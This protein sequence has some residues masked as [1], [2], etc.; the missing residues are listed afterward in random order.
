[1]ASGFLSADAVT[2]RGSV[3]RRSDRRRQAARI[4]TGA[5]SRPTVV[6]DALEY[7]GLG[8]STFC[9]RPDH[10]LFVSVVPP[11]H[12]LG[13][14]L[15]QVTVPIA[16]SVTRAVDAGLVSLPSSIVEPLIAF[17]SL[18]RRREP[19]A[20]ELSPWRGALVLVGLLHA[21]F[22]GSSTSRHA[23]EQFGLALVSSTSA[24]SRPVAVI[25]WRRRGGGG[26]SRR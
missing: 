9:P 19:V 6:V 7:P 25:D 10:I 4:L 14:L 11:R 17:R 22:A 3:R 13:P 26:A 15:L 23:A 8:C 20:T 5:A 2:R 24:S 16:P 21:G 18:R 12:A 1:M